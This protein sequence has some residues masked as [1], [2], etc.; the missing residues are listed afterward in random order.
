VD[1]VPEGCNE[2]TVT[3]SVALL[4]STSKMAYD[5]LVCAPSIPP[6]IIRHA[7]WLY[8]RF[9]LSYRDVEDLL[10]ERGLDVSYETARQRPKS[11]CRLAASKA[12]ARTIGA[13]IR[14]SRHD[15]ASARCSASN[16]RDQPSAPCRFTLRSKTPSTSN[17]IPHPAARSASSKTK[18]SGRGEPLLLR[19][20]EPRDSQFLPPTKFP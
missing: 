1:S 3:R 4:G 11:D 13:R 14:I 10:A 12:C 17:A 7:V 15:D 5:D 18:R 8:S 6:A 16:R 20:F 19:E 2:G 9:T